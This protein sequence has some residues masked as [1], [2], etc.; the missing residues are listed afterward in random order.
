M[1][2]VEERVERAMKIPLLI[3][4]DLGRERM[5][6]AFTEDFSIGTLD[7]IIDVR[8]REERPILWTSNSTSADMVKQ[9]GWSMVSRILGAAPPVTL[10]KMPDQRLER[11]LE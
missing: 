11:S 10:A 6:G 4:D 8:I 2:L 5:R 9:Y 3:L 7:R 1:E